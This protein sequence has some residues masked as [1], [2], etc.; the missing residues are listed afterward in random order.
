MD[1]IIQIRFKEKETG[2]HDYHI[3][4]ESPPT[5]S[6][7]CAAYLVLQEV[8]EHNFDKQLIY[9]QIGCIYPRIRDIEEVIK[10]GS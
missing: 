4:V 5:L 6:E 9:S 10:I 3:D 2:E 8:L 1:N 7:L